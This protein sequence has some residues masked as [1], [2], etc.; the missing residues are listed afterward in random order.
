MVFTTVSSL[1]VRMIVNKWM[2]VGFLTALV[3]LEVQIL[4][5]KVPTTQHPVNGVQNGRSSIKL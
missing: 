1:A 3:I 2:V 5:S 4:R